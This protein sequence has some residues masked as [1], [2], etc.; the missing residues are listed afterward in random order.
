MFGEFEGGMVDRYA[1]QLVVRVQCPGLGCG[2]TARQQP[3]G[4]TTCERTGWVYGPDGRPVR[5]PEPEPSDLTRG[6]LCWDCREDI[7]NHPRCGVV[8]C[9]CW[10]QD[11]DTPEHMLTP[12]ALHGSGW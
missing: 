5:D 6:G 8:G 2:G 9:R 1:G 11:P 3:D 12:P 7:D 10:C 4:R